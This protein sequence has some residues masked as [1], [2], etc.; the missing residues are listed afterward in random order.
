M[1]N[2]LLACIVAL[3]LP[4]GDALAQAKAPAAGEIEYKPPPRG[5]PAR[6]VGGSSRG[7]EKLPAIA[8]LAPEH[9]GLTVSEQPALYWFVSQATGV[10]IEITL[11]DAQGVQPII[12]TSI[13]RASPGIHRVSLADF[14]VRLKPEEEY[15][16]SVAL[17]ADEGQRSTDVM[18]QG[19]LKRVA[20]PGDLAARLAA[21][22][23]EAQ[24]KALASAGIWYDALAAISEAVARAPSDRAL[25]EARAALLDQV[26]LS[27]VAAFERQ[28]QP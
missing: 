6:R 21:Q 28:A 5:A 22:P 16:W 26:G 2:V 3:G 15:Q 24:A 23:M 25:R 14:N 7:T 9:I 17:V 13:T 19:A 8:V 11:I 12:E 4:L 27:A 10:R 18:S 1:K 20:P